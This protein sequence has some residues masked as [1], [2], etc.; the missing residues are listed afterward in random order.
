LVISPQDVTDVLLT[1]FRLANA[2]P[3]G[4]CRDRQ[5]VGS[6][7]CLAPTMYKKIVHTE[8]VDIW[9][10]GVTVYTLLTGRC[11]FDYT[12][13]EPVDVI[14]I[15]LPRLMEPEGLGLKLEENPVHRIIA[16]GALKLDWF[17]DMATVQQA[18]EPV[19]I[20]EEKLY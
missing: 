7:H 16:S 6:G 2:F 10:L 13:R 3:G 4:I 19:E 17:E 8:R 14:H 9:S 18:T 15:R 5:C 20:L 1:D 12:G 11:P